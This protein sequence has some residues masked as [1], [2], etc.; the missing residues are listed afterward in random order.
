[1]PE[2]YAARM[3]PTPAGNPPQ[4]APFNPGAY[5]VQAA[6]N[7]P[8]TIDRW[9]VLQFLLAIPHVFV[10]GVLE[11][12]AGIVSFIA[13]V[14][15]LFTGEY[16]PGLW[17][18]SVGVHRWQWRVS[19]YAW[20]L[21]DKYPPFQLDSG[22]NDPGTE[23]ALFAVVRP[24]ERNRLTCA[25]RIIWAIPAVFVF[26]FVAIAIEVV[27]FIAWFAV[28]FTGEWPEGMRKFVLSGLAW[29]QRV[30]AYANL[31]V[32]EYPPFAMEP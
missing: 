32:D 28:L 9:R 12:V 26:T 27:V 24:G 4:P 6:V 2:A 10:V 11:W 3:Q 21:H 18:F 23:P 22:Q 15:I 25:L 20:F 29:G 16:P 14:A 30:N 13:W 1:M 19:T 8:P 7:A 5:P 31:L 17:D